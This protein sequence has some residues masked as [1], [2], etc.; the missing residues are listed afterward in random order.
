[1]EFIKRFSQLFK[2]NKAV[3]TN[4]KLF[5]KIIKYLVVYDMIPFQKE[6]I[7]GL[8]PLDK[9][10][11]DFALMVLRIRE[12]YNTSA[13][14]NVKILVF[15]KLFPLLFLVTS[16]VLSRNELETLLSKIEDFHKQ[17]FGSLIKLIPKF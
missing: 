10:L 1:M 8:I 13:K 5:I 11:I 3:A 14:T 17:K 6:L 15:Q 4:F 9:R 7:K 2:Q 12:F 16:K